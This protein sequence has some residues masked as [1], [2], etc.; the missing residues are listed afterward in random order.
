VLSARMT[1][2]SR[3]G[4]AH[5]HAHMPTV[6]FALFKKTGLLRQLQRLDVVGLLPDRDASHPF[7]SFHPGF[8]IWTSDSHIVR[9]ACRRHNEFATRAGPIREFCAPASSHWV[10]K[11]TVYK[12]GQSGRFVGY[13]DAN[14]LMCHHSSAAPRCALR[15]RVPSIELSASLWDRPLLCGRIGLAF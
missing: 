12:R 5:A 9:F 15:K 1:S 7:Q 10:F 2:S 4:L 3:T 11:A 14:P 6:I 13:G 8:P